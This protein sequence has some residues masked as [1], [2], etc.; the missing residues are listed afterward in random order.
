MRLT[1]AATR[2]VNPHDGA[3]LEVYPLTPPGSVDAALEC[4]RT[5][6]RAWRVAPIERRAEVLRALARELRLRSVELADLVTAEM[7]KPVSEARAE[8]EKSAWACDHFAKAGAG[9]LAPEAIPLG[10]RQARVY[11]RPLGVV[12]A[13]MPWNYPVWQVLRA[14]APAIMAGNTV[15]LK[16][17]PNVTGTAIAVRDAFAAVEPGLLELVVLENEQI[18]S[19]IADDRVAAVTVTG[20]ERAGISVATACA[21]ALKP[22]VLELGGSDPFI[23]L[24]D[25][26][27]EQ[28][29]AT[30]ATA[31]FSNCGQSCVAAKRFIVVEQAADAFEEAFTAAASALVVGDPRND[32]DLGPMARA[33]LRDALL[34]QVHRGL[35][36]GGR[37]LAGGEP[38]PGAGAYFTPTIIGSVTEHNVLAREETFGPAAAVL[39]VRD[40]AQAIEVANATPYGL[41]A[42]LWTADLDLGRGLAGRIEAGAV[43]INDM[44]A[45]D[46]RVPFGG[47]KRSGWGR[48]LGVFGI[49]EFSNAQSVVV[50]Q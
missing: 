15:V 50:A 34:D 13:I 9:Y 18:A 14:A 31:R 17:A 37:V 23:V 10:Q 19:L 41:S 33:D 30:A 7:G 27:L 5:K 12:L 20:S 46:P 42:S 11:F 32:V 49:R 39:R 8:V 29:A 2:S 40:L 21:A 25:A 45:S 47:I 28:A 1:T 43:Y 16:H 3:L 24:A 38:P 4:A 6:Q 35:D 48:E 26:D 36:G 22:S 44:T